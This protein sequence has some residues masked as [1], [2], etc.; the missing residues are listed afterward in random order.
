MTAIRQTGR[1]LAADRSTKFFPIIVA[2]AFFIGAVGIALFK[3]KSAAGANA[4]SDTIFI[5]V[6]AHS[7][8]FSALYF[9]IIPIVFVGSIIGVSQT[10]AAIPRILK[11]FQVDLD[12]LKLSKEMEMPNECL[13]DNEQ[14]IYHGGIYS[15]QPQ[16]SNSSTTYWTVYNVLPLLVVIVA[17]VTGLLVTGYVPPD[18]WECRSWGELLISSGWFLSAGFDIIIK[19]FWPLNNNRTQSKLFWTMLIKDSVATAA[20]MGGIIAIQLGIFNRCGCYTNSGRTGLALPQMPDVAETLFRR[21]STAYPAITFTGIAIELVVIPVSLCI[22]Y[23]DA[24]RIFVQRDDR[25]S[26]AA[27]LW[28]LV[29]WFERLN[30]GRMNPRNLFSFSKLKRTST[31]EMER[32]PLT[33]SVSGGAQSIATE[34]ER[35]ATSPVDERRSGNASLISESQG[36]NLPSGSGTDLQ[37]SSEGQ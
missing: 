24:L 27:W 26:N 35:P 30:L 10:E 22:R 16:M 13:V 31:V 15:W 8:A 4:S 32:Q 14:R 23:I 6:E 20:T 34:D 11:R 17:T 37:S 9:W 25:R 2:Q 36:V 19:Y 18:G 12:R 33:H 21:L 29:K 7:I 3:T 1:A 5:N 28:R